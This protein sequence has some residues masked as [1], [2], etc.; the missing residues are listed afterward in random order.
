MFENIWKNEWKKGGKNYMNWL[1]DTLQNNIS[2]E[3]DSTSDF[4]ISENDIERK[5]TSVFNQNGKLMSYINDRD[6]LV[7]QSRSDDIKDITELYT[8]LNAIGNE[9]ERIKNKIKYINNHMDKYN[10]ISLSNNEFD[11]NAACVYAECSINNLYS[12]AHA[13]FSVIRNRVLNPI[14]NKSINTSG[15]T[16]YDIIRWKK[17]GIDGY[18]DRN[19]NKLNKNYEIAKNRKTTDVRFYNLDRHNTVVK[20]LISKELSPNDSSNGAFFWSGNSGHRYY[21]SKPDIYELVKTIPETG[22]NQTKFWKIKETANVR[23]P[24]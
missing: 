21:S 7:I 2:S 16:M 17:S 3:F 23:K 10:L 14:S 24:W 1:Q 20:A 6:S 15:Y 22:Q 13:I 5:G 4:F 19:T 9:S 12:E 8:A 18:Y 11:S